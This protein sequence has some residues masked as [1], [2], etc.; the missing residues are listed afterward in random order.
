MHHS[1]DNYRN[2]VCGIF[3]SHSCLGSGTLLLVRIDYTS[4]ASQLIHCCRRN[5][6][7]LHYD[8]Y[9][10]HLYIASHLHYECKSVQCKELVWLHPDVSDDQ[11]E[12]QLVEG[13]IE[14]LSIIYRI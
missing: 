3:F 12:E 11:T 2:D 10:S 1:N 6:A 7:A 13:V 8:I 14:K 5:K 9:I 4:F